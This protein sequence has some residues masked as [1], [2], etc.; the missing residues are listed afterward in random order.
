MLK[1]VAINNL[2][3]S[4]LKIYGSV[5]EHRFGMSDDDPNNVDL[6]IK[7]MCECKNKYPDKRFFVINTHKGEHVKL[8]V[9]PINFPVTKN[10]T[11]D[12][13]VG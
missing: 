7:A 8:E 10:V 9:F 5:P 4:A 3:E 6:I 13:I 1:R 12:E 2:V 11:A